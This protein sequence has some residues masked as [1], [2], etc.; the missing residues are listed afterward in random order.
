VAA[1]GAQYAT[2]RN[3]GTCRA[4]RAELPFFDMTIERTHIA[5]LQSAIFLSSGL[6]PVVHS[7]SFAAVTGPKR[8][9]WLVETVGLLIA[10]I[11]AGLALAAARRRV[12]DET[13]LVGALSSAALCGVDLRYA[14]ARRRSPVYFVDALLHASFVAGWL[15]AALAPRRITE[16]VERWRPLLAQ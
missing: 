6:W 3:R 15:A 1:G 12:S 10:S 4:R 5:A 8:D 11:G 2:G 16:S 7:K 13:A 9:R 14:T